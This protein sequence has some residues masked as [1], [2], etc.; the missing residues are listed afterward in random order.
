[1]IP[2]SSPRHSSL[3]LTL[4]LAAALCFGAVPAQ[5]DPPPGTWTSTFTEEF[6]GTSLD[7]TRWNTGMRWAG[8]INDEPQA[9]R[10]ENVAVGGGYCTIT[11]SAVYGR[12]NQAGG[13]GTNATVLN[14]DGFSAALP[15]NSFVRINNYKYKITASVGG[16]TPTQITITRAASL[17]AGTGLMEPVA[18]NTLVFAAV[19]IRSGSGYETDAMAYRSGAIQTYKKW[20]QTYGYFEARVKMSSAK[21]TW[22]AFWL[23]PDRVQYGNDEYAR[24][25]VGNLTTYG[26]ENAANDLSLPMGNE[27]DVFEHM[28]TWKNATTGLTRSHHGY[29]WGY[30]DFQSYGGW[31]IGAETPAPVDFTYA[32]PDTQF[33]TFGVYWAPGE[34]RFYVDGVLTFRRSHAETIGICPHYLILNA[35]FSKND[36]VNPVHLTDEQIVA[37]LPSTMVIDYVKVWSGTAD[38]LFVEAEE[39]ADASSTDAL[40]VYADDDAGGRKAEKLAS[41]ADG[42][43]VAYSVPIPQAGTYNIRLRHKVWSTRGKFQLSI[44]GVNQG[45]VVDQYA[46]A[47]AQAEV[48]LGNKTFASAGTKEFRFT[49]AGKNTSSGGRDLVFDYLKIFPVAAGTLVTMDSEGTTGITKTGTWP[50]STSVAGYLGTNYLHDDNTGKGTKSVRFAPSLTAA[51][52][53]QVHARWSALANRATNVPIDIVQSSGAV[54]T[55]TVDQTANNNAWVLLGTYQLAPGNAAVTIRTTGTSGYVVADGVRF[56]PQ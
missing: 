25:T 47:T 43:Y 41:N 28:A 17:P 48:D 7:T 44:D 16:S 24:S 35:A 9:Y 2:P 23:M 36:W 18:D 54:A 52:T 10:P 6:T 26:D 53:Y 33:H 39:V 21:G 20:Q 12:I 15:V 14:I 34:M 8:S 5:A 27:I 31:G 13:H 42:D 55:V 19:P 30:D 3:P 4:S 45:P 22:P 49:V 1:M 29:F 50:A 11:T 40:T 32:N 56:T 37:T 51:G 38:G 46:S